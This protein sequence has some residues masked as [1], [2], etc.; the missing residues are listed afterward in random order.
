MESYKSI[1]TMFAINNLKSFTQYTV[2]VYAMNELGASPKSDLLEI[3]TLESG[4]FFITKQRDVNKDFC[5][6]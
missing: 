1:S 6:L 2:R 5:F 4:W 3:Q